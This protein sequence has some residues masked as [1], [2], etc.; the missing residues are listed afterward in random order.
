MKHFTSTAVQDGALWAV[1][2]DQ[3]PGARSQ[4]SG[5]NPTLEDLRE[6]MSMATDLKGTEINALL[7]LPPRPRLLRRFRR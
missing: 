6:A 5:A 1:Q 2:S 3:K 4:V 7:N